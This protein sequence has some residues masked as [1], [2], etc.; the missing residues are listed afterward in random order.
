[1]PE[2]YAGPH[3]PAT[4]KWVRDLRLCERH[5]PTF[6]RTKSQSAPQSYSD[7]TRSSSIVNALRYSFPRDVYDD[8][9]RVGAVAV[10]PEVEGLPGAECEAAVGDGDGFGGVS[11]D[12]AGVRGHVVGAFVVVL[13]AARFGGKLRDPGFEI[14]EHGGVGIL[15]DH[16]A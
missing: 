16:E 7:I 9:T 13:P 1:R 8:V 6:D 4:L 3:P 11:E 2:A 15:L 12:G 14:A 5:G 10:F